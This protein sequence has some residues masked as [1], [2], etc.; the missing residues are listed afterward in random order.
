MSDH[1]FCSI[2]KRW[3]KGSPEEKVRQSLVAYL[4]SQLHYP[5]NQII[6]EKNINCLPH[7]AEKPTFTL[8]LRRLD[9]LVVAKDLHPQHSFYPLVL[10]ECKAT[11]INNKA[12]RQVLGYNHFLNACFIAVANQHEIQLGWKDSTQ[13]FYVNLG[14]P[15]YPLLLEK[16]RSLVGHL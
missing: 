2:R 14:L 11:V 15:S 10:I 1:L 13:N 7:L 16:G 6:I 3:I 8:P 12:L 9:L 5:I 4:V